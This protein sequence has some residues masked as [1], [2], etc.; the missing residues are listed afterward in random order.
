MND[1]RAKIR[2]S[3][4]LRAAASRHA[5][6]LAHTARGGRCSAPADPSPKSLRYHGTPPLSPPPVT[7]LRPPS[8]T[9]NVESPINTT[10]R[11]TL[12]THQVLTGDSKNQAF[13]PVKVPGS[14]RGYPE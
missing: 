7:A 9:V 2:P 11:M 5:I 3:V 10:L 14:V 6:G 8:R 4:L 12:P 13:I 1:Q